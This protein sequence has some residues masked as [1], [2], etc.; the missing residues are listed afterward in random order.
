MGPS[1]KGPT[2]DGEPL[3]TPPYAERPWHGGQQVEHRSG[4]R[5]RPVSSDSGCSIA[6]SVQTCLR[7]RVAGRT[8]STQSPVPPRLAGG[9]RRGPPPTPT[10]FPWGGAGRRGAPI[11]GLGRAPPPP[12]S[13][14]RQSQS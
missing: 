9:V 3:R 8:P 2:G 4:P 12:P 11:L 6:F 14:P 10:P 5:F 7:G 1:L 13:G